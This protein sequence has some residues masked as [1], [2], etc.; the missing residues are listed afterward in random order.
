MKTRNHHVYLVE[1]WK[2]EAYWAPNHNFIYEGLV[3]I[4]VY[5]APIISK[6]YLRIAIW[7]LNEV[8]DKGL[9]RE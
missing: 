7:I 1:F 8:R 5:I 2:Y 4:I 3:Y 6:F 9:S